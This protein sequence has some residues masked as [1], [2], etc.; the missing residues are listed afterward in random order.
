[1]K[2]RW[3]LL[4]LMV[5]GSLG[6]QSASAPTYLFFDWGKGELSSDATAILDGVAAR[7]LAAP[8][9]MLI[10]GHSDRSGSAGPNIASSR[11][12]AEQARD[13]LAAHGV[14][15]GAMRVRSYGE[16]SPI[17]ATEDGVREVQNRRVEIRFVAAN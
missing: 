8:G 7:Y 9:P 3:A 10:D 4:G 15:V 11:K 6:A 16:A 12:R 17:I 14:P 2:I 1:M 13:Y 5:A